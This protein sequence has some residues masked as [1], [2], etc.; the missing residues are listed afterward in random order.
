MAELL[1]MHNY[2]LDEKGRI[3]LPGKFREAFAGGGVLTLGHERC[4]FAFPQDEYVRRAAEIDEL[5]LSDERARALSR[6]FFG[7]A[8]EV[9]VDKNGRLTIP[10]RL[11]AK[12]GIG[13]EVVVV[14]SRRRLEIWDAAEWTRYEDDNIPAYVTGALSEKRRQG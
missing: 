3:S 1:G 9:G 13:R 10:P 11:R 8:E 4:L 7:Y 6:F 2:Q 14:G 12:A 5:P